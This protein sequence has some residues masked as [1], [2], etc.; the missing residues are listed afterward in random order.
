MGYGTSLDLRYRLV[1]AVSNGM[2]ARAA[3]RKFEVSAATGTRLARRFRE[4][5]D[6][7]PGQI[8]G[9]KKPKLT[10]YEPWLHEMMDR[11]PD[12]TLAELQELLA[13]KGMRVSRQTINSTLKRL[14]YS[15]KK[16]RAGGRARSS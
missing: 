12:I 3:A 8:G 10:P 1:W 4:T 11:Q 6:Y 16:N 15:Y 5:G 14:G 9:Q 2:S 13:E 7:G